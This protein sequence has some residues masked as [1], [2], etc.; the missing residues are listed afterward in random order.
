VRTHDPVTPHANAV[1][2]N[3]SI[4]FRCRWRTMVRRKHALNARSRRLRARCA[5]RAR[6]L[7]NPAIAVCIMELNMLCVCV[8]VCVFMCIHAC[9]YRICKIVIHLV[10]YLGLRASEIPGCSGITSWE[11]TWFEF[12]FAH[13]HTHTCIRKHMHV[14]AIFLHILWS[15][16]GFVTFYGV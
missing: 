14:H 12:A 11:H 9:I 5:L 13:V 16:T 7:L 3:L 2:S 4:A 6:G 8:C 15:V 1:L 10:T